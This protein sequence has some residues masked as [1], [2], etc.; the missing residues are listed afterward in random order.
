MARPSSL[1][2]FA[3]VAGSGILG[4]LIY[5]GIFYA[6]LSRTSAS[7][8][9]ETL[10]PIYPT[11]AQAEREAKRWIQEGERS[12]SPPGIACAGRFH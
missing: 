3:T 7:K 5:A 10:R 2:V 8:E 4:L 6:N 12:Q 9:A 11:Q 1:S